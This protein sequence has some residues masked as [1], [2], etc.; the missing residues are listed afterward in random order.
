MSERSERI[1]DTGLC[2]A[3]CAEHRTGAPVRRELRRS[4]KTL[5]CTSAM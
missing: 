5:E 4:Q 1:M 2:E 3:L